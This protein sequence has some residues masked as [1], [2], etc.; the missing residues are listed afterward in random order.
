MKKIT[1]GLVSL[2]FGCCVASG[3]AQA[4][5]IKS[6]TI[7]EIG[8]ASGGVGTSAAK[9]GGGQ[10]SFIGSMPSSFTS[11]ASSDGAMLMGKSQNDGE[12]TTGFLF[13]PGVFINPNTQAGAPS[14]LVNSDGALI[15][16]LTGW[17]VN[18]S[19]GFGYFPLPPDIGTLITSLAIKD[20]NSYYYTADWSHQLTTNDD[21]SGAFVGATAFWHLEGIATVPEPNTLWLLGVSAL[22]FMITR[23][24][25][26]A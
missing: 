17:G 8:F 21:P 22:G 11:F 24:K 19:S 26:A 1:K 4:S 23:K 10:F 16:N 12:F 6:M 18:V 14:G 13:F 15:L 25:N 2:A 5:V 9:L 20:T 7:E 3:M